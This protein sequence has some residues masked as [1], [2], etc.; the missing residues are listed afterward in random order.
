MQRNELNEQTSKQS[1][2]ERKSSGKKGKNEESARF[3]ARL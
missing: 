2:K 3:P 1:E